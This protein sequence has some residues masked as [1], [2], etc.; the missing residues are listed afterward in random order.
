MA[1]FIVKQ[2]RKP[3][4][5]GAEWLYQTVHILIDSARCLEEYFGPAPQTVDELSDKLKEVWEWQCSNNPRMAR[6][7]NGIDI[8]TWGPIGPDI[9]DNTVCFFLGINKKHSTQGSALVVVM[10]KEVGNG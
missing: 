10:E 1:K 3:W 4:N 5:Q 7:A 6:F 8:S 9:R 2:N